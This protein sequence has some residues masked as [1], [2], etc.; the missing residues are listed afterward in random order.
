V[1]WLNGE[2][3]QETVLVYGL[4]PGANTGAIVHAPLLTAPRAQIGRGMPP[5]G[6]PLRTAGGSGCSSGYQ[7]PTVVVAVVDAR[8]SAWSM[9]RNGTFG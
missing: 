6:R 9:T 3:T 4:I 1:C 8:G 7:A 5:T 2:A